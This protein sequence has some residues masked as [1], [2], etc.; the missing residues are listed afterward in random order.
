MAVSQIS[1]F[2]ENKPGHLLHIL[3]VFA[4]AG[5]SVRGFSMADTGDYG[6]ARFVVDKPAMA[7]EV[8]RAQSCAATES[9]VLCI[10]LP[11]RLGELARVIRIFAAAGI[12]VIYSYTLI[13]SVIAI[14][15]NNPTSAEASLKE[16]AIELVSQDEL[17]APV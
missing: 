6:I 16:H 5:I 10:R 14:H 17:S 11:D 12:N 9:E 4:A 13:S 8:L 15:T 2:L 7:L 1:V 3:D